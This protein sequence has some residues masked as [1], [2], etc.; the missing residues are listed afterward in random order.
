MNYDTLLDLVIEL[1]YHLAMSGAET[2]RIEDSIHRILAA[3]GIESEVF[4]ITNCMTVSIRTTDGR[5]ITRMKRIG[6]HGND[7]DS[8]EKFNSSPC[9]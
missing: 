5:T 1:G 9:S 8:V 6:H 7:L 3:Y 2:Y 4:A